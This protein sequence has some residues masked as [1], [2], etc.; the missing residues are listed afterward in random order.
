VARGTGFPPGA[1]VTFDWSQGIDVPTPAIAGADGSFE[2]DVLVFPSEIIG[3]RTMTATATDPGSG[4]PLVATSPYLVASGTAQP[5][6]FV[7]RR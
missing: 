3:T 5:G 6:D 1:Q 4:Q 7:G 2:V